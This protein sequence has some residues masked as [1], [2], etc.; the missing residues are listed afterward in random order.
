L[1]ERV[2]LVVHN[3]VV[4]TVD[5][6]RLVDRQAGVLADLDLPVLIEP[7]KVAVAAALRE[8][9]AVLD[10]CLLDLLGQV[11]SDD[12]SRWRREAEV[13]EDGTILE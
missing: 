1:Y 5:D 13:L 8:R 9:L 11:A 3:D 7:A 12:A 6:L 10:D 2:C 4:L